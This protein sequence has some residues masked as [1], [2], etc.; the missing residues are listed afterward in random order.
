MA[1]S[2]DLEECNW[3]KGGGRRAL[4]HW[5]SWVQL[6]RCW[7]DIGVYACTAAPWTR[8][9]VTGQDLVLS[10]GSLSLLGRQQ[11]WRFGCHLGG[12]FLES[13]TLGMNKP[14]GPGQEL[15]R[16]NQGCRNKWKSVSGNWGL[17]HGETKHSKS[18][19]KLWRLSSRSIIERIQRANSIV[20]FHAWCFV[21]FLPL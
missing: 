4:P 3:G 10:C 6:N 5:N 11:C 1:A 13:Q 16:A 12:L 2:V 15:A 20:N 7:G 9:T 14:S 19:Q 17:W 8:V 21:K 18:R